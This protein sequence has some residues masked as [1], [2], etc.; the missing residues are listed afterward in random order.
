MHIPKVI[1]R[2]AAVEG[3]V[4]VGLLEWDNGFQ[5]G[6]FV[7]RRQALAYCE[8]LRGISIGLLDLLEL[9]DQ[10]AYSPLPEA[11][12]EREVYAQALAITLYDFIRTMSYFFGDENQ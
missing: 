1:F 5:E 12:E 8:S 3:S 6:I 7:S 11:P 10:I 9:R 4:P 2:S